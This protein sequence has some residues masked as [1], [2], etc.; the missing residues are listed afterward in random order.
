MRHVRSGAWVLL[1]VGVMALLAA[2]GLRAGGA[3]G[4][5]SVASVPDRLAEMRHHF[6]QVTL[7]YE[8]V[9]RGDLPSVKTPAAELSVMETP[10]GFPVTSAPYVDAIRALGRRASMATTI[11]SAA[12]Q[13]ASMFVQCGDCHRAVG[14]FPTPSTR[15]YPDVGGLV[16][17]MLDHQ[18]AADELL[19]GLVIPSD[20]L[21]RRGAERL[22]GSVLSAADLPQDPKLTPE[23]R[24]AEAAV[25]ALAD[26]AVAADSATARSAV[27][28]NLATT[29]A[30]CHGLHRQLWG[31][32]TAN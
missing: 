8:A 23:I 16:G 12:M 9:I 24:K 21:W 29:C 27:Y 6:V 18:K 19:Q 15:T 5:S 20:A 10:S 25:H 7:V 22:R 31:P 14:I 11:E 2:T 4:R 13:T 26:R 32:R 28:V 1:S 17:H 30:R 3:Q